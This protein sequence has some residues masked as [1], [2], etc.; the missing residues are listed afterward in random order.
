M[1]VA[2][3]L[4]LVFLLHLSRKLIFLLLFYTNLCGI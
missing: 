1:L 4:A 3:T 2:N